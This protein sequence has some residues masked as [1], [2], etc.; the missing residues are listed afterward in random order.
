MTKILFNGTHVRS[1]KKAVVFLVREVGVL[2]QTLRQYDKE[3]VIAKL[4][5]NDGTFKAQASQIMRV[6]PHTSISNQCILLVGIGQNTKATDIQKVG[7]AIASY[8]NQARVKEACIYVDATVNATEAIRGK[9]D[10]ITKNRSKTHSQYNDIEVAC[11]IAF[12]LSIRNYKFDKYYTKKLEER[13]LPLQIVSICTKRYAEA[14]KVFQ[15]KFTPL[16]EGVLLARNLANEVPNMLTPKAFAEQCLTLSQHGIKVSILDK[17]K[18]KEHGM[19]ALLGVAQGSVNEPAFVTLEWC[20]ATEGCDIRNSS[21]NMASDFTTTVNMPL[22]LIGKGVTFDSGGLNL[23]PTI[24]IADMKYDM[25]GAA[26]VVGTMLSLALRRA[27]VDVVGVIGLVENMPSGSAQ[28][29][30]DVV[31]SMSGQTIEIDNTDAEGRLV[32]ADA[33][34]YTQKNYHPKVII[35]IATLTGAIVVALGDGYAGTFS[36][37]DQLAKRIYKAG[38]ASGEYVWHLPMGPH[39]DKQIDS[40][41]ADIKNCGAGY[42]GGSITAAHFLHRFIERPCHWAHLDIAGVASTKIDTSLCPK[43]GTGFGVRLLN[44]LIEEF[45]ETRDFGA[46]TVE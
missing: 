44:K 20:G 9:N 18:M 15:K 13:K 25:S 6:A 38:Q 34:C 8:L 31:V 33:I 36:N 30:G 11:N 43:G 41:I 42:G 27:K 3:G 37:N 46:H 14:A 7:G 5:K 40:D 28:R 21:N 12:G 29:P 17:V 26:A 16:I 2:P 24:A 10:V 22:A 23:K 45:Y 35:D 19:N 1:V 32:L 4:V 39:Y